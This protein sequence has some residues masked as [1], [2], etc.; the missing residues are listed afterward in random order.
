MIEKLCNIIGIS[1]YEQLLVNF[2]K[3]E[4][5]I[6][7]ADDVYE[8]AIGNLIYYKKG[9]SDKK[10]I[11][12]SAHCDEVGLQVIGIKNGKIKFKILG[13]IKCYNL[14]Q[15]R[16]AFENGSKGIVLAENEEDI[17]KYN[18]ENLYIRIIF[19]TEK[20]EL[21]DVC[22]FENNYIETDK[23]I[24]SKGLDN[25]AACAVLY[26]L[27]TENIL[28][29]YDTYV[30]FSVQEE[31][32]LKGIKVAISHL[33]PDIFIGVDLTPE[34]KGNTVE[35]LKGT[36]IKI[37]DS[38]SISNRSLVNKLKQ[39][40]Q[41]NNVEYQVEVNN[42]GTSEVAIVS[43]T[44]VGFKSVGISIPALGLHT[45]NVIVG[46]KDIEETYRLLKAYLTASK[47]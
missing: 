34:C 7:E 2:I 1:G 3:N 32:G 30:V 35:C 33:K 18:Y 20:I 22:T 15:Q 10:K 31:I 39:I 12:V 16:V 29:Y 28:F 40:A 14:Y 17:K 36:A 8:D 6:S 4:I 5:V 9:I 19:E 24:E 43:E 38:I 46:K 21:G 23:Y 42:C 37:S 13:N 27:L 44:G 26:K 41:E 45:A 47:Y 11:L 25:R